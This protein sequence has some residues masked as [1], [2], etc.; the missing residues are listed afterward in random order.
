MKSKLLNKLSDAAQAKIQEACDDM[1]A[2]ATGIKNGFIQLGKELVVDVQNV[3]DGVVVTSKKA[4]NGYVGALA[5]SYYI[6]YDITTL[7]LPSDEQI[8]ALGENAR[9]LIAAASNTTTS[10][11]LADDAMQRTII[12]IQTQAMNDAQAALNIAMTKKAAQDSGDAQA[13]ASAQAQADAQAQ[14]IEA[15]QAALADLTPQVAQTIV[16]QA[17]DIKAHAE[18]IKHTIY[19][20]W[21]SKVKAATT[22]GSGGEYIPHEALVGAKEAM[23]DKYG[24]GSVIW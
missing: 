7:A 10:A 2:K 11:P 18:K 23:N 21:I 24:E 6:L 16:A 4:V 17:A 22:T 15:A 19:D 5:E 8:N 1:T 12:A 14:K 13:L 20:A 9:R 3:V